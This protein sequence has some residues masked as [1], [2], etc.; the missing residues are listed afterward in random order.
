MVIIY[1]MVDIETPLMG[2]QQWYETY[3]VNKDTNSSPA[4]VDLL[5]SCR[6]KIYA[7]IHFLKYRH[8]DIAL[9]A[10]E[11]YQLYDENMEIRDQV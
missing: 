10:N 2:Q 9:I 7:L 11:H 6:P 1:L 3:Y 8:E 4:T 5:G